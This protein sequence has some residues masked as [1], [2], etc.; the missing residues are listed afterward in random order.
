MSRLVSTTP[1]PLEV[2]RWRYDRSALT[3]G[4]VHLGIGAF[5]RAHQA[6]FTEDAIEA[7]GGDW[8]ILG[9]SLRSPAVRDQLTPQDGL[10]TLMKRGPHGNVLRL[11][12]CVKGVLVAPENPQAVIDAIAAPGTMIV[13]LTIT[14]KGYCHDPATGTLNPDHPDVMHDWLNP[15]AP[16]SALGLIVAGLST[17]RSSGLGG[18]TLLCCDNLPHNGRLLARVLDAYARHNDPALADWIARTVTCPSTMVDRIV[19]ATTPEDIV[20]LEGQLGARDEGMVKAEPFRQWVIEDRFAGPRPAWDK[21]G[22][23]LV[24]DVAPFEDAKLRLLNGS[25]STLAYLGH[26]AGYVFV[27][28]AVAQPALAA[29]IRRLMAH[30]VAPT[31]AATP[32]MDLSAYQTDLMARFANPALNHRTRQI[33]MDGSQKLPQRLLNTVRDQLA[34]G[35]PIDILALG[36]AAWMRYCL[37]VDEAG[38]PYAVEDPLSIRFASIAEA[39]GDD[40]AAILNGFLGLTPVFGEDLPLSCPFRDCVLAALQSLI[41]HGAVATIAAYSDHYSSQGGSA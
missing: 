36:V 35:G 2:R 14:E 19:P 41:K 17:R 24:A 10:Y 4:I 6:E 16:R 11:I 37:G 33:A 22:V 20:T 40:P 23:Q 15:A 31:L 27:H 13:S 38:A 7:A 34:A 21:A 32:G 30:E 9:V 1:L 39:A 26:L 12:G 3:V 28:E 18:L 5:H 25:H 29:L 8:G